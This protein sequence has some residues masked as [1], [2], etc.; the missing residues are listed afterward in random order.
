MVSSQ[1]GVRLELYAITW[2]SNSSSISLGVVNCDR[3]PEKVGR[4]VVL[5]DDDVF[6]IEEELVEFS[7]SE[8]AVSEDSTSS[9]GTSKDEL[10]GS[11]E[12]SEPALVEES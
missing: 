3:K 5:D 8:V 12:D 2:L 6:T 1:L 7:F 11:F 4:L 9:E 10:D